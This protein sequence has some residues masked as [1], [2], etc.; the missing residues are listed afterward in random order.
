MSAYYCR[1]FYCIV[2][3]ILYIVCILHFYCIVLCIVTFDVD[4]TRSKTF[5]AKSLHNFMEKFQ[6]ATSDLYVHVK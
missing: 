3:Y 4:K 6:V 1:H 2:L 5:A